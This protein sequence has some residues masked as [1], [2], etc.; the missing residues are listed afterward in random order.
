MIY[1]IVGTHKE[2]RD[3]GH[4][5]FSSFG[6]ATH[7]I[8][9]E[10]VGSLEALIDG[11]SL[12]GEVT[13]IFCIQLGEVASSKEEMLR[14]LDGMKVSSNIFII[15][16]P[17]ADVHLFNKLS[18]VSVKVIDA[19]EEK[20]KDVSVFN[21]CDSFIARDK[22]QAWVDFMEL[23]KSGS[24]EAIQGALW[25]KFQ[26]EWGKVL[27]GKKS[28]FN[29]EECERFGGEIMRSSILAH[30]GERDLFLELERIVL[31]V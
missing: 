11:V 18:K 5:E 8:Y 23:K 30:R 17:F 6:V 12:F 13:V 31:S 16:E 29:K 4:K 26:T 2:R 24:A 10:Q 14:L 9:S 25:W 7:H 3:K 21:F 22:K 1:T 28:L 27:E 15:D 20:K 19:R